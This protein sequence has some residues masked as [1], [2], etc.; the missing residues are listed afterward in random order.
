MAMI[1]RGRVGIGG[2]GVWELKHPLPKGRKLLEVVA[3]A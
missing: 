2:G 3:Q 1:V